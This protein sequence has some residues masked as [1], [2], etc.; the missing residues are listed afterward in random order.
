MEVWKRRFEEGTGRSVELD[1][2]LEGAEEMG[3]NG[4]VASGFA[5]SAEC[6]SP[7]ADKGGVDAFEVGAWTKGG[8]SLTGWVDTQ[9]ESFPESNEKWWD[10]V[11]WVQSVVGGCME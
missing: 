4:R 7:L 2:A 11:V 8:R 6:A 3:G 10:V 5:A 1:L 9:S